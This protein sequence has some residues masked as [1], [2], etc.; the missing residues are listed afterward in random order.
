LFW[1]IGADHVAALPKWREAAA[2]AGL[3]EFV[4]IARPGQLVAPLPEPFRGRALTGFPFGVSSSQIR[5]RIKA[6]LPVDGLVPAAVVE[7]IRN[8]GLYL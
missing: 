7:A 2:L 4:V 3:V 5:A 1:L 6:G 8:S